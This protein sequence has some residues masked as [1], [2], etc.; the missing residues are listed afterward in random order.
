MKGGYGS[1]DG[2]CA[3]LLGSTRQYGLYSLDGRLLPLACEAVQG[4]TSDALSPC[5]FLVALLGGDCGLV[6][7]LIPSRTLG[8]LRSTCLQSWLKNCSS[9][10]LSCSKV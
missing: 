10:S 9:S 6:D 5:A 3:A 4:S 8:S 1:G 7:L 2:P